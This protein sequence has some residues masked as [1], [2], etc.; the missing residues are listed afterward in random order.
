MTDSLAPEVLEPLLEGRFG[1]PYHF[2]PSCSSTQDLLRPDEEPEGTVAATDEQTAGRGRRGRRWEAPPAKAIMCSVLLRPPPG[3]RLPELSL[4][5]GVAVAHA[6]EEALG[7]SAQIKWPNDVL[8]NRK[9]VSGL[10]AET[11]DGVVIL[12]IGLNVNQRREELPPNPATPAASLRTVDGV[13]RPRAPILA[14][15]LVRLEHHYDLWR[16]GGLD[17]IY[18]DLGPRDFL[19]GR[20]VAVDGVTGTALTID[21]LGRLEIEVDGERRAIESG[22]V[23]YER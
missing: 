6:V 11:R 1:R 17:A 20:R 4:V 2:L 9:K 12:G 19:R 8:V 10:L 18:A 13:E 16:E 15:I 14:R 3:R 23:T 22:E 7:L 5:G 21:R